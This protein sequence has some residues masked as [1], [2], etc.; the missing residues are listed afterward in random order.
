MRYHL[1]QTLGSLAFLV[2]AGT[3]TAGAEPPAPRPVVRPVVAPIIVPATVQVPLKEVGRVEIKNPD[4]AELTVVCQ[5]PGDRFS[6]FREHSEDPAVFVLRVFG[7]VEG[8]YAL[9]VLTVTDG[10]IV[11]AGELVTTVGAPTPVPPIPD[12]PVPPKPVDESKL[13]VVVIEE[14]VDASAGRGAMFADTDLAARMREK[15]H[16]W[17]V[18]DQHVK[19]A[20][21]K[22]P[23]EDLKGYLDAAKG[24]P[25]PQVFLVTPKAELRYQ[26]PLPKDAAGVAELLKK[27][28]G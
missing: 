9:T 21:G 16:K 28:G 12:P 17:R 7:R 25:L 11:V 3:V 22:N 2:A 24:K 13:F 20:D 10:K 15:G 14:T 1:R 26:G 4:K 18:A 5:A 6:W 8:E 23:P 19:S 27:H